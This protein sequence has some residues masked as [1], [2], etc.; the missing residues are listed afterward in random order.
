MTKWI[1]LF[2]I[3]LLY[4]PV[5]IDATI[6]HVAI[7][8]LSTDLQATNNDILWIIDIYSLFMAGLL[9]PMGNLGDKLGFKRLAQIGSLIFALASLSASLSNT[10][11]Q[12]ILSRILLAVGASMILPATLA[13]IRN[14]FKTDQERNFALGVWSAIGAGGA[15]IGPLVGG[16]LLAYFS[17]HA[18]FLINLPVIAI[19]LILIHFYLPSQ[20]IVREHKWKIGN[21]LLL[22]SGILLY[23]FTL[24]TLFREGV[25]LKSLATLVIGSLFLF[26]FFKQ[27]QK[28]ANPTFP[29]DLLKHPIVKMGIIM[30]T[31]AMICLVG[32][33]LVMSQELQ[34]VYL[35][36]PL[37]A[38]LFMTPLM[39]ASGVSGPIAG[40]LIN[41][42]S[43]RSIASL[44]IF[45]SALSFLVLSFLNI[46]DQ[47]ILSSLCLIVLGFSIS[48]SLLSSTSAIMSSVEPSKASSAG[49]IEGMAYELGAGLGVT[50][51]G[52]MLASIYSNAFNLPLTDFD[53]SLYLKAKSSIAEAVQVIHQVREIEAQNMIQESANQA[54]I[55]AHKILLKVVSFLLV[56]LATV[57][58][59]KLPKNNNLN[60]QIR[61]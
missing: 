56:I 48:T 45:L 6:L 25:E 46:H 11:M 51:F 8:T 57:A 38:A 9:L 5:S 32:F 34:F 12:L 16:K 13:A 31:T 29:L 24:K 40:I 3:I 61:T 47:R 55:L 37:D 58:F 19:C 42:F 15:A 30:A 14:I 21:N 28:E 17:W 10:P 52:I 22:L 53:Q 27:D 50:I 41:N 44:G 59:F 33:E 49:A 23:I 35:K 60:T 26:I 54:F 39:I 20:E 43:L 18:V 4:L 2:T 36:S 7:P 1:T